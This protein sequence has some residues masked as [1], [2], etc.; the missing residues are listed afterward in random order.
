MKLRIPCTCGRTLAVDP[1]EAGATVTCSS[2]G[3]VHCLPVQAAPPAG[4]AR[5]DATWASPVLGS[6]AGVGLIVA[7]LVWA[8]LAGGGVGMGGEGGGLGPS[9]GSGSGTGQAGDGGGAG[10]AGVGSA[11]DPNAPPPE[12]EPARKPEPARPPQ[13]ATAPADG[14]AILAPQAPPRPPVAPTPPALPPPGQPGQSGAAGGGGSG[15]GVGANP[16]ARGDLSFTLIWTYS[17]G[18]QGRQGRGGPDVDIWVRDPLG[19]TINTSREGIGMGP[20]PEGGKADFDDQGAYGDG[21]GGGPERIFWPAGRAPAGRYR[22]G[23]RWYQGRGS[24]RYKLHVYRGRN[25]LTTRTGVLTF[26]DKGKNIELGVAA[27]GQP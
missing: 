15:T 11:G 27:N 3:W 20:T 17:L 12:F 5:A 18:S 6:L 16:G 14:I 1:A 13:P 8:L 25:L 22:Y 10:A 23:V 19:R 21:D 24:A 4:A 2:C 9:A 7:A 26:D